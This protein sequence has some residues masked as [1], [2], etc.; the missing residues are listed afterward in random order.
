MLS[1]LP[2]TDPRRQKLLTKLAAILQ[3]DGVMTEDLANRGGDS[4]GS[5]LPTAISTESALPTADDAPRPAAKTMH[6][7][8]DSASS[9]R[10]LRTYR[11]FLPIAPNEFSKLR[12]VETEV[13]S[14]MLKFL[15]NR[16]NATGREI[17]EQIGISFCICEKMLHA[18]KADRL[19][20]FKAA[21]N[22]GDYVYE[23]TEAGVHRGRKFVQN[24]G[25]FG[26]APVCLEDYAASVVVQS[27]QNYQPTMDNL[28]S[29]FADL[30]LS[31]E[32]FERLGRAI[33]SGKGLFLHGP[34]GNGKTSIAERVTLAYGASIWVPRAISAWGEVIRVFDPS[35]HDE[36]PLPKGQGSS[37]K[38]RSIIA[39]SASAGPRSSWAG[40]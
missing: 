33:V 3:V 36:M 6:G 30:T 31:Q 32:I 23:L 21:A 5:P 16:Q 40:N 10:P 18:M 29:A 34:P 27:L 13:E 7:G 24:C 11:E 25:Y 28:R 1:T 4:P 8:V 2:E 37:M 39:G 38:S 22:L 19:V 26:T 14:L 12:L 15:L 9:T 20:I 35:C 17:A